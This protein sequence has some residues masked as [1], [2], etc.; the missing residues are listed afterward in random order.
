MATPLACPRCRVALALVPHHDRWVAACS[1][2]AG[3]W[4]DAREAK[5]LLSPFGS[6]SLRPHGAPGLHSL[7][8]PQCMVAMEAL[9]TPIGAI[10]IDRC[11]AHGVW[12]DRDEM[13]LV[14]DLVGRMSG[15]APGPI[16]APWR[17]PPAHASWGPAVGGLAA[18]A[19]VG[20]A[21]AVAGSRDRASV[22]PDLAE[23]AIDGVEVGRATVE[24]GTAVA[25]SG[26]EIA[27]AAA[28]GAGEAVGA[29][30]ECGGSVI[31]G[32]GDVLGSV[33]EALGG[34]FS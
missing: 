12:F 5:S 19:A 1:Q 6:S 20:T 32:A 28:D 16:P 7:A 9:V 17:E 26:S 10:E 31:E 30:V 27:A 22:L 34:L 33:F 13:A 18:G 4:L 24:I 25:D 29:A 11:V 3:V 2:C 14:A 15:R 23:G 8:C 21:A